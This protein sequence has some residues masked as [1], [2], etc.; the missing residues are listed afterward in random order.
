MTEPVDWDEEW[1]RYVESGDASEQARR[2]RQYQEVKDAQTYLDSPHRL[3]DVDV[4]IESRALFGLA[5]GL[6]VIGTL[7]L[8]LL[9]AW[10][11]T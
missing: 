2:I 6:V 5:V 11:L 7:D 4:R 3:P 1:M 8:A 9:I 10:L